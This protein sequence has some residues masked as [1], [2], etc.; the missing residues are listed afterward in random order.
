[1]P[2]IDVFNLKREKVGSLA[3]SDEVFGAEVKEQLFYEVV[4]AQLASKRQGTASAKE[5]AA[6]PILA[7]GAAMRFFLTRLHD[8]GAT[9]AGSLVRPKDPMEYER[10]LAAHRAGIFLLDAA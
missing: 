8:W 3:L 7:H 6:L 5:R 2:T 1:M 9:P 10:K 4:K